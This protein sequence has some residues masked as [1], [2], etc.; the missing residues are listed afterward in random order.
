M[1]HRIVHRTQR[2]ARLLSVLVAVVFLVSVTSPFAYAFSASASA[3]ATSTEVV[4]QSEPDPVPIVETPPA[5]VQAESPQTE[6]VKDESVPA[7]TVPKIPEKG[8]ITT[9]PET[10]CQILSANGAGGWRSLLQTS[11]SGGTV[12]FTI[13]ANSCP[14]ELTF[15]SYTW[16]DG[17]TPN[18]TNGYPYDIQLHVASVTGVYGPGTYTVNVALPECGYYQTD[19]YLGPPILVLFSYGHPYDKIIDW[20][21]GGQE[22]PPET[23]DLTVLK[24]NDLNEN[25]VRDEG[26]PVIQGVDITLTGSDE[27]QQTT[28][29][30][31]DG[32][33]LF[34]E[35]LAGDYSVT[36]SAPEGWHATVALP[37]GVSLA[38]G[39]DATVMIG[40]AEDPLPY[41]PPDLAIAKS[42]SVTTAAPGDVVTYTLTYR[43]VGEGSAT[44]FVITDDY[45]ERY[46]DV[47]DP[48]GGVVADGMITWNLA[49]PLSAE[50][51]PQ[52]ITYTVKVRSDVPDGSTQVGNVVTISDPADENLSNNTGSDTITVENPFL[53]FTPEPE[54]YLPF[55]GGEGIALIAVAALFG[56]A[57]IGLRLA[58]RA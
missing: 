4:A 48:A 39:Q 17:V 52:V 22:C 21:L 12:T 2:T 51:D 25:G 10:R 49:G 26:E 8:A 56:I 45:D 33:A 31:A 58:R 19:L 32:V 1:L 14:L 37:I 47:V 29:T 57:G 43:N 50:D 15:S 46:V 6:P 34:S 18:L 35:L 38:E 16:P 44:N 5:V 53:P 7:V 36:E 24:F 28:A 9:S 54:E 42:A 27:Y 3:E 13:P 23:S 55:T 11:I 41:T 30:N 20:D 40:N